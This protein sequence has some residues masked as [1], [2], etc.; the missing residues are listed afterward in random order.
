ML[1]KH[2]QKFTKTNQPFDT[3]GW[4]HI[5]VPP[6]RYQKII[7]VSGDLDII[8]A[9]A[10]MRG[11][12]PRQGAKLGQPLCALSS[13]SLRHRLFRRAVERQR[14]EFTSRPDVLYVLY[15]DL[16][17]RIGEIGDFLAIDDPAFVGTFPPRRERAT[18]LPTGSRDE[19]SRMSAS[20]PNPSEP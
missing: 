20:V 13:G 17:R 1:L 7:Y 3:D 4:K 16:W 19:T 10:D 2:V 9:S 11:W 5:P 12:M 18:M 15:E 6:R 8:C 14:R